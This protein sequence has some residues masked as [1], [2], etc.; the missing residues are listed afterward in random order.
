M[1]IRDRNRTIQLSNGKIYDLDK[2][3]E[4]AKVISQGDPKEYI[5]NMYNPEGEFWSIWKTKSGS[6]RYVRYDDRQK[7]ETLEVK[8]L[9]FDQSVEVLGDGIKV[10]AEEPEQNAEDST[11]NELNEELS[12]V[13]EEFEKQNRDNELKLSQQA[14]QLSNLEETLAAVL[15]AVN[16]ISANVGK[17]RKEEEK[18]ISVSRLSAD[19]EDTLLSSTRRSNHFK[20]HNTVLEDVIEEKDERKKSPRKHGSDKDPNQ[21]DNSQG[22]GSSKDPK[23]KE[24]PKEVPRKESQTPRKSTPPTDD[25]L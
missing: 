2:A 18:S 5:I 24:K 3:I 6:Y 17:E 14:S 15:S 8:E 4:K 23:K 7:S 12:K 25:S 9:V 11:S 22:G 19:F 21:N 10:Y 13:R 16:K 1:C 20:K